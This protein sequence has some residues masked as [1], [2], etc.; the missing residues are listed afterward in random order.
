MTIYGPQRQLVI[1]VN[2]QQSGTVNSRRP[3][4]QETEISNDMTNNDNE[5]G[6]SSCQLSTVSEDST[7]EFQLAGKH[8]N[9][10]FHARTCTVPDFL[11]ILVD[12]NP[13]DNDDV[14]CS[15]CQPTVVSLLKHTQI[16]QPSLH[17]PIQYLLPVH[18]RN[19]H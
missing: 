5:G 1:G 3:L 8:P 16:I 6:G 18:D 14:G 12:L 9:K 4:R 13:C 11:H 15:S 2:A 19:Y 7:K 10:M 17:T